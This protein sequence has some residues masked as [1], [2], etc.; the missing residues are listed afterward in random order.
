MS[1]RRMIAALVLCLLLG[2]GDSK[3]KNNY[4]IYGLKVIELDRCEYIMGNNTL[5]HK[6]NC[7]NPVHI[8]H[9]TNAIKANVK[10]EQEA[11]Q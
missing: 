3:K 11:I 5:T 8:Y 2:C 4:K 7:S 6:G 9:V 1:T 10:A